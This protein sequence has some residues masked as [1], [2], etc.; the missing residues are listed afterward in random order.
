[1]HE[2]LRLP[3]FERL[4]TEKNDLRQPAVG[5]CLGFSGNTCF[6]HIPL[7]KGVKHK[8]N[9]KEGFRR[10]SILDG[11]SGRVHNKVEPFALL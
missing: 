3:R 9:R 8:V 2:S 1:M 5:F 4:K 10:P 6:Q 11:P 7:L